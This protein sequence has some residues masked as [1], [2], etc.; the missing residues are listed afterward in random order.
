MITRIDDMDDLRR[1]LSHLDAVCPVLRRLRA[2]VGDPPLRRSEGGFAGLLRIVTAQQIS[3][4]AARSIS[5][6]LQDLGADADAA[7]FL[8]LTPETLRAAGLSR[9][10]IATLTR[11]AQAI[12]SGEINLAGLGS[13]STETVRERLTALAGIG[14]WTAD[15]YALFC[16]GH[17]DAFAP[18]DLALAEAVR[19]AYGLPDRPGVAALLARAEPWRPWRGAA[20]RLLWAWY[21]AVKARDGVIDA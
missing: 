10:K 4:A 8:A 1:G 12:A 5:R 21:G 11:L 20:A 3:A 2:D 7:G 18:G 16:L 14:P 6:R 19:M 15:V 17:G 9:P 13:A